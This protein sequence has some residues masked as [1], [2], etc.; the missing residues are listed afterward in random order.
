MKETHCNVVRWF[1]HSVRW[2]VFAGIVRAKETVMHLVQQLVGDISHA[3]LYIRS[4]YEPW[5]HAAIQSRHS[6]AK[7]SADASQV[8]VSLTCLVLSLN[9]RERVRLCLYDDHGGGDARAEVL[10]QK[11]LP[12]SLLEVVL[13]AGPL[14]PSY[15]AGAYL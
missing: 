13:P 11:G 10:P 2:L 1:I 15:S 4:Q 14:V 3:T 9:H 7:L 6:S 12:A 5:L 8:L